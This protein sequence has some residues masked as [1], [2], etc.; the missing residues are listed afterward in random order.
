MRL[1]EPILFPP[2]LVLKMV[3]R[4]EGSVLTVEF[5]MVNQSEGVTALYTGVLSP[6]I[7][8]VLVKAPLDIVGEATVKA[9][10]GTV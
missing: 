10:V 8:L 4:T 7:S 5:L 9:V 2:G 1:Q 3:F 6:L